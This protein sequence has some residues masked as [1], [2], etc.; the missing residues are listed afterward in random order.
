MKGIFFNEKQDIGAEHKPIDMAYNELIKKKYEI[1]SIMPNSNKPYGK[2]YLDD[3]S[4]EVGGVVKTKKGFTKDGTEGG[5]FQGRPHSQGGI[6]AVN[7]DTNT[8]IEVEGGE[9]VIT[10]DA[11]S[12]KTKRDFMGKKMTNKEILSYINQSG[13]GVALAKGGQIMED[14]GQVNDDDLIQKN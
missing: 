13:G 2:Y 12:D 14:G 8:P 1:R 7:V 5:Y 4:F 6:K 3:D 10:K 11:V 9:V